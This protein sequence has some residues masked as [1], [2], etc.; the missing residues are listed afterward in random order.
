MQRQ[1]CHINVGVLRG[2]MIFHV[3]SYGSSIWV[4]PSMPPIYF[5][6]HCHYDNE[7]IAADVNCSSRWLLREE[8]GMEQAVGASADGGVLTPPLAFSVAEQWCG[9]GLCVPSLVSLFP[10]LFPIPQEG[11]CSTGRTTYIQ[12]SN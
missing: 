4:P 7:E 8:E 6:E 2:A 5:A 11:P 10:P 3:A 1:L 9:H 12:F